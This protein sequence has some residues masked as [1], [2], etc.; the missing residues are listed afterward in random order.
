VSERTRRAARWGGAAAGI[1]VAC[2]MAGCG[3]GGSG[4]AEPAPGPAGVTLTGKVMLGYLQGATVCL[5]SD[6][7]LRCDGNEPTAVS[8]AQGEYSLALTAAQAATLAASAVPVR[9]V[10]V[11]PPA[12]VDASS[13]QPVGSEHVLLSRPYDATSTRYL[14]T[15]LRTRVEQIVLGGVG[16][17]QAEQVVRRE[18]GLSALSIDEDYVAA[19]S[20]VNAEE[21]VAAHEQAKTWFAQQARAWVELMHRPSDAYFT[22]RAAD[23]VYAL[24]GAAGSDGTVY[25]VQESRS[26][27]TGIAGEVLA[28]Q[29]IWSFDPVKDTAFQ[30]YVPVA[31]RG[32]FLDESLGWLD[33]DPQATLTER[34]EG[35]RVLHLRSGVVIAAEHRDV[36]ELG[37]QAVS[38]DDI[39]GAGEV[40]IG[41]ATYPAGARRFRHGARVQWRS[42]GYAQPYEEGQPFGK[43]LASLDEFIAA[44][45]VQPDGA[46]A[47]RPLR[48]VEASAVEFGFD[49]QGGVLFRDAGNLESL[50]NTSIEVFSFGAVPILLIPLSERA[51]LAEFG[52]VGGNLYFALRRGVHELKM[53]EAGTLTLTP[54]MALN[55]VAADAAVQALGVPRV[56]D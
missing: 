18:A 42:G 25:E 29:R 38:R 15:P 26:T 32:D 43:T 12:S 11:V 48:G 27:P 23:G 40:T 54:G 34:S 46:G 5:D 6:D 30:G 21:A 47:W 28:T 22:A 51:G 53:T 33:G 31:V 36:E 41:A 52:R 2:V 13:G 49:G 20:G 16:R 45:R 14:F 56:P 39:G 1:A 7:N 50:G 17:A 10:A 35:G 55:R 4:A 9:L 8:D 19:A 37:G 3:G 44:R 24:S